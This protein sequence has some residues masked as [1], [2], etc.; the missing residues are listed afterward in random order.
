VPVCLLL[1]V[2]FLLPPSNERSVCFSKKGLVSSHP[3]AQQL[4]SEDTVSPQGFLSL[5]PHDDPINLVLPKSIEIPSA[6]SS[7]HSSIISN[8]ETTT[9]GYPPDEFSTED[10]DLLS[11]FLSLSQFKRLLIDKIDNIIFVFEESDV[12]LTKT[13]LNMGPLSTE[14]WSI[15]NP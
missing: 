12:L 3:K 13:S 5:F 7:T 8:N 9:K 11:S 14:W 6:S 10:D 4:I 1:E 2:K 15:T